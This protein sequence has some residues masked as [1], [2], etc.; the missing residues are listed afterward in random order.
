M[1]INFDS[2]FQTI[3]FL[4]EKITSLL[5]PKHKK[6]ALVAVLALS[7]LGILYAISK[8]YFKA[9]PLQDSEE[10]KKVNNE[11][12]QTQESSNPIKN[13]K[14]VAKG[15]LG[16]E[17]TASE[18]E[19]QNNEESKKVKNDGQYHIQEDSNL[20]IDETAK[21]IEKKETPKE[22]EFQINGEQNQIQEASNLSLDK[23]NDIQQEIKID[24]NNF[25]DC[26]KSLNDHQVEL[27]AKN[28]ISFV[29]RHLEIDVSYFDMKG[30]KLGY[31]YDPQSKFMSLHLPL[32]V[33]QLKTLFTNPDHF[34]KKK[35][36]GIVFH[37]LGND[38]ITDKL[39]DPDIINKIDVIKKKFIQEKTYK[40]E[41]TACVAITVD[42]E[43]SIK[44]SKLYFSLDYSC[45]KIFGNHGHNLDTLQEYADSYFIGH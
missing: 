33:Q 10:P 7:G 44:Y 26:I 21:D 20:S 24:K 18:Q 14:E 22:Q 12:S 37:F 41:L 13:T 16:Q 28:L 15:I 2:N 5:T 19:K 43:V 29:M 34:N 9:K 6:I 32:V 8:Y 36:F 40:K 39:N 11:Q 1:N 30:K 35:G 4:R 27:I 38:G 3:L 23:A 42:E 45:A 17:K 25:Q 31:Y